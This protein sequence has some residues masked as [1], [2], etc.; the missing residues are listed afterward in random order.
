MR[1]PEKVICDF[2][3]NVIDRARPWPVVNYPLTRE[4]RDALAP[5]AVPPQVGILGL[6]LNPIDLVP[7]KVVL[8]ICVSCIDGLLPAIREHAAAQVAKAIA[9][10]GVKATIV[11]MPE[12]D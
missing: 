2:C 12:G 11:A 9:A 6:S 1:E 10:G 8:E 3:Q 5:K 4:Q 7:H